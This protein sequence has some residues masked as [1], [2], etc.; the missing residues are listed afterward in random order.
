MRRSPKTRLS[1]LEERVDGMVGQRCETCGGQVP[2]HVKMAT[3]F[4]LPDGRRWLSV[5]TCAECGCPTD[6]ISGRP[7][8]FPGA[9][10][11]NQGYLDR[12]RMAVAISLA[13]VGQA[14]RHDD[15]A[16]SEVF[17]SAFRRCGPK[18]DRDEDDPEYIVHHPDDDGLVKEALELMEPGVLNE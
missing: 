12:G 8:G 15:A 14:L 9:G 17:M 11:K 6:S 10:R 18:P 3:Y 2:R 4:V 5:R 7:D 1:D 16:K 13:E